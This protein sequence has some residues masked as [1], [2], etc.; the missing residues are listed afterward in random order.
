M[1]LIIIGI[2]A[3]V[4]IGYWL[5]LVILTIGAA[6]GMSAGYQKAREEQKRKEQQRW[7]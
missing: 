4:V 3:L 7:R 5:V 2:V 6:M 1:A